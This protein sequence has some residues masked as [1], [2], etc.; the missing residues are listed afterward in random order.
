MMYKFMTTDDNAEIV[1]SELK[2]NGT[3]FVY[4]EKP[5]AK[6]CFHHMTCILPSYSIKDVS[7]FSE[8]D[9]EK[10][11]DLIKANSHLMIESSKQWGLVNN[12]YY[13]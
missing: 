8:E 12:K 2:E 11:M 3:V 7:G 13:Y 9:V 1:H 10:Y 6:D 5:D 4:V